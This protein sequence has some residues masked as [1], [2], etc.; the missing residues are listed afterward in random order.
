MRYV[1][2]YLVGESYHLSRQIQLLQLAVVALPK[3]CCTVSQIESRQNSSIYARF[4]SA[5]IVISIVWQS[6][7]DDEDVSVSFQKHLFSGGGGGSRRSQ[8]ISYG[9]SVASLP[10]LSTPS[11]V[12]G[13]RKMYRDS[14]G[15]PKAH[16]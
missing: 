7:D 16:I 15:K 2:R 4:I 9:K 13:R 10:L 12:R 8:E 3:S 11:K 5:L 14:H 6:D 1:H